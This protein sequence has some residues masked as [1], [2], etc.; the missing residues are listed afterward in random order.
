MVYRRSK[1]WWYKF[2]W[3]GEQIRESSKHTNKRVVEQIESAR[4]TEPAKGEV[5]I[6]DREVVPTLT[7]FAD[8]DFSP[9][10]EARFEN[11]PN[12]LG[13]YRNGIRSLKA[14]PPLADRKLD[15]ITADRIAGFVAKLREAGLSVASI[16][17]QLEV[18]RRILRLALEWGD[19]DRAL[20]RVE[21]VPGENHRD[22]V[23]SPDEETRD[24]QAATTVGNEIEAAYERALSGIRATLRGK[25]PIKPRDP[26]QLRDVTTLLIDCGLRPDECF[27]LRWEHIREGAVHVPFG[28]TARRTIPL[29]SRATAFLDMRRA[30]A[31]TEWLFPPRQR[32][33]GT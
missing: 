22:R 29:T 17:R 20:P 33:R 12:T 16:N 7:E 21:T 8:H 6:R 19:I 13:Y 31:K 15:V 5:G 14:F 24:L 27:R 9:L 23:L 2:T 26:F 18:M 30:V 11:K 4:K 25:E 1:V 3:N 10:V 32:N 28:K